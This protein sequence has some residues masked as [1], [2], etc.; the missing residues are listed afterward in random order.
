MNTRTIKVDFGK[1]WA[2]LKGGYVIVAPRTMKQIIEFQSK[3]GD[4]ERKSKKSER[5]LKLISSK[6]EALVT[7]GDDSY[8]QLE[9]EEEKLEKMVEES[10]SKLFGV[11]SDFVKSVFLKG[12]M[13]DG[14]G[15]KTLTKDDIDNFDMEMIQEISQNATGSISGKG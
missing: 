5:K 1:K 4:I 14:D 12:E 2:E 15:T 6:I 13:P 11:M 3:V 7:K 10:N 9:I 8:T